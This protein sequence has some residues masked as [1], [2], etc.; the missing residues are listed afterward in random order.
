M[1][2]YK[3]DDLLPKITNEVTIR[4]AGNNPR[5]SLWQTLYNKNPNNYW[6]KVFIKRMKE[7]SSDE[8]R[9]MIDM[10]TKLEEELSDII[11]Y[12]I[13][14]VGPEANKI[15]G[16]L[17][18][19]LEFFHEMNEHFFDTIVELCERAKKF[20]EDMPW[21]DPLISNNPNFLKENPLIGMLSKRYN[22][23]ILGMLLS[24]KK[25]ILEGEFSVLR[26]S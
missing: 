21:L 15:L 22:G 6:C 5:T 19:H 24:N 12:D 7:A 17:I 18:K 25:A 11:N 8:I 23:I 16:L 14:P 4:Y 9:F 20:D 1:K 2:I 26:Q 10:G 3:E 13:D